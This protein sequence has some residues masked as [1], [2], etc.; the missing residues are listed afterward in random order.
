MELLARILRDANR[1][2]IPYARVRLPVA[3]VTAKLRGLHKSESTGAGLRR[4]FGSRGWDRRRHT[5]WRA[6]P[7]V[8]YKLVAVSVI[9]GG[10]GIGDSP[11]RL[12][13]GS[14]TGTGRSNPLRAGCQTSNRDLRHPFTSI[15]ATASESSAPAAFSETSDVGSGSGSLSLSGLPAPVVPAPA[16]PHLPLHRDRPLT[17][18]AEQLAGVP[19]LAA[20][21]PGAADNSREQRVALEA[22]PLHAA[23]ALPVLSGDNVDRLLRSRP[24][25]EP[26]PIR[27]PA[28][29]LFAAVDPE[30]LRGNPPR[31]SGLEPKRIG[32]LPGSFALRSTPGGRKWRIEPQQGLASSVMLRKPS[33]ATTPIP[34]VD[35]SLDLRNAIEIG[36][37]NAPSALKRAYGWCAR[38]GLGKPVSTG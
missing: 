30:N 8:A 3:Y 12:R 32:A 22:D 35:V 11:D 34:Q 33:P 13:R 2:G 24:P 31:F 15:L 21:Q 9:C 27:E 1:L 19:V 16:P 28:N 37:L 20:S 6:Y 36:S 4:R 38:T 14:F 23:P 5:R 25:A 10:S 7:P 17:N 26:E 29:P 18:A